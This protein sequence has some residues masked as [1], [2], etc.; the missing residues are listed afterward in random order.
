MAL[1]TTLQ[2]EDSR[3]A[4]QRAQEKGDWAGNSTS[5]GQETSFNIGSSKT[6]HYFL[7]PVPSQP[8]QNDH[9][10]VFFADSTHDTTSEGR[11]EA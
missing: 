7:I 8:R 6:K 9:K 11:S 1:P 2:E 5:F 10:S 3:P 4:E